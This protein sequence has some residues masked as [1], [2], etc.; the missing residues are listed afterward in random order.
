MGTSRTSCL[1]QRRSA[2]ERALGGIH[3]PGAR[4]RIRQSAQRGAVRCHR[5]IR[6]HCAKCSHLVH[7]QLAK[8]LGFQMADGVFLH[9]HASETR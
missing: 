3:A 8:V 6:L 7:S 1:S 4:Q 5:C 9:V 2:R